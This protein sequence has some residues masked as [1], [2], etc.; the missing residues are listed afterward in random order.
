MRRNIKKCC[1]LSKKMVLGASL[2]L[3]ATGSAWAAD[4]NSTSPHADMIEI[5][6]QNKTI[7]G[8]VVDATGEP[9]IGANILVKGTTNGVITDIDGN[10]TLNVLFTR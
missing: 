1:F 5:V 2:A 10:F 3:V 4:G 7:K 8:V 6:M 9:I